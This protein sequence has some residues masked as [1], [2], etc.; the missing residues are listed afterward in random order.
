MFLY[1]LP[2]LLEAW[3]RK[4]YRPFPYP[5]ATLTDGGPPFFPAAWPAQLCHQG[6][7]SLLP[8][9]CRSA[10]G[11]QWTFLHGYPGLEMTWPLVRTEHSL[12]TYL[13]PWFFDGYFI[14]MLNELPIWYALF[15]ATIGEIYGTV[16]YTHNFCLQ[17]SACNT[18]LY[19]LSHF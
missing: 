17:R 16:R 12:D 9:V 6:S 1:L 7:N 15:G 13:H 4:I 11:R 14:T 10:S 2:P 19:L 8:T 3:Q 5:W 18:A